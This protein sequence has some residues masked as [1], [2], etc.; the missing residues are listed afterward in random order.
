MWNARALGRFR[1][2]ALAAGIA[3][4]IAASCALGGCAPDTSRAELIYRVTALDG[5]AP[6]E[7]DMLRAISRLDVRLLEAGYDRRDVLALAPDRLRVV[8]PERVA[9]RMAEIRT[10]LE[11]PE[12]LPVRLTVLDE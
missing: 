4:G 8:L 6:T 2:A 7:E 9:D 5:S 10:I 11:A 12:G 1:A 3:A